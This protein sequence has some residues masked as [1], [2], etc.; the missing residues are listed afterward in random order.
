M[1]KFSQG[2]DIDVAAELENIKELT[3]EQ[4]EAIVT[5]F[6]ETEGKMQAE[7]DKVVREGRVKK[8]DN[9]V[10]VIDE[11]IFAL[12]KQVDAAKGCRR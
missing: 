11:K 2:Q 9:D 4:R 12:E 7:R 6:K 10:K 1:D 5:T 3:Q 8:L